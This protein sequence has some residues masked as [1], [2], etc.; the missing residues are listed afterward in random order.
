MRRGKEGK[1]SVGLFF[2]TYGLPASRRRGAQ[3]S[4]GPCECDLICKIVARWVSKFLVSNLFFTF[5]SVVFLSVFGS[6]SGLLAAGG[7]FL[8]ISWSV[9]PTSCFSMDG[10]C[11]VWMFG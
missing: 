6:S 7:E 5:L 10:P 8:S 11:E 2:G 3:P 9:G 1:A 4:T